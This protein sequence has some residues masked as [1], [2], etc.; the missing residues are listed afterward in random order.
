[1]SLSFKTWS[2]DGLLLYG[3]DSKQLMYLY[4]YMTD[5]KVHFTFNNGDDDVTMSSLNSYAD[6]QWHEVKKFHVSCL[7]KNTNIH[8]FF[9]KRL[10]KLRSIMF[11]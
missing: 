10:L 1:M 6:N 5:G 8:M 9:I 3:S 7:L 2:P 11:F 4:L